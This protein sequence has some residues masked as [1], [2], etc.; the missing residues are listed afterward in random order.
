MGQK[1]FEIRIPE[2]IQDRD[3]V[4]ELVEAQLQAFA[5]GLAAAARGG[6]VM[7]PVGKKQIKQKGKSLSEGQVDLRDT[8]ASIEHDE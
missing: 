2:H 7:I 3:T 4:L 5:V 6:E 8:T 1:E